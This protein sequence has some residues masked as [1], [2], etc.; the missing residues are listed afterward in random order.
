MATL[1]ANYVR[2]IIKFPGTL[3]H[4]VIICSFSTHIDFSPLQFSK[5]ILFCWD[6][7]RVPSKQSSGYVQ[8]SAKRSQ[9][10]LWFRNKMCHNILA[11]I[12]KFQQIFTNSRRP[13]FTSSKFAPSLPSKMP[14]HFSDV[15]TLPEKYLHASTSGQWLF[16]HLRVMYSVDWR[17]VT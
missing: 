17:V 7:L 5:P 1:I 4:M 9:W 14:P 3:L 2:V 11:P 13:I 10:S 6:W 8:S 16:L 12:A 15:A